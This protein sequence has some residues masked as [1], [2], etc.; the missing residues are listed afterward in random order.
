M[1]NSCK[2]LPNVGVSDKQQMQ[3]LRTYSKLYERKQNSSEDACAE[4]NKLLH[5]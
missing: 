2:P 3:W 1:P 5:W 4:T